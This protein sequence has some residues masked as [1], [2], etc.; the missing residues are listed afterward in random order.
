MDKYNFSKMRGREIMNNVFDEL[1]LGSGDIRSRL[2]LAICEFTL[3][4]DI[5][6]RLPPESGKLYKE[7]V[8]MATKYPPRWPGEGTISGTMNRIKNK[9]GV[10]IASRLWEFREM[11]HENY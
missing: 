8:D 9:T 1:A 2:K 5:V 4:E 7:I 6:P 10:T 11:M 3:L